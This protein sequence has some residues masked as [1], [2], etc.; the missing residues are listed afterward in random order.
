MRVLLRRRIDDIS[1]THIPYA[2]KLESI[3]LRRTFWFKKHKKSQKYQR[4][5]YENFRRIIFFFMLVLCLTKSLAALESPFRVWKQC[6]LHLRCD[7]SLAVLGTHIGASSKGYSMSS[8][9]PPCGQANKLNDA[10]K[11]YPWEGTPKAKFARIH[12][13]ELLWQ[14]CFEWIFVNSSEREGNGT[15]QRYLNTSKIS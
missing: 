10:T 3:G 12:P 15:G 4:N 6:R 11:V 8:A 2:Q 13:V 14:M 9:S 7:T 5:K 1:K